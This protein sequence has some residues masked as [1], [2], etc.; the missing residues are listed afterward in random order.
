MY[1]DLI[2]P[3]SVTIINSFEDMATWPIAVGITGIEL[4]PARGVIVHATDTDAWPDY[5]LDND[6]AAGLSRFTLCAGFQ[7]NGR[8]LMSGF[9]EYWAHGTHDGH[10]RTDS[11]AHP[12]LTDQV[13]LARDGVSKT[14]WQTNWA[15]PGKGWAE[16][17]IVPQP[18]QSMAVMLVAG[19]ARLRKT[20]TVNSRSQIV[21]FPLRL[22]G[23]WG[24][25]ADPDQPVPVPTPPPVPNPLPPPPPG[26]DDS[27][28]IAEKFAQMLD[29]Y[30]EVKAVNEDQG[31]RIADLESK[32][33]AAAKPQPKSWSG[34][35]RRYG[36]KVFD[37]VVD[38]PHYE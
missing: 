18:E 23:S 25:A 14:N 34:E 22:T 27:G 4:D 33:D 38:K 10:L 17:S 3:A 24:F 19:D 28:R 7:V 31:R 35:L 12:L 11:G 1:K 8:W 16:L 13:V 5:H 30:N 2:D 6:P 9:F 36:V 37:V 32:Q 26:P 20:R 15:D 21:T 29:L